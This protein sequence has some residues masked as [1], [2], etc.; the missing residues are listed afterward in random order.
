MKPIPVIC[1]L[2]AF[3]VALILA[4]VFMLTGCLSVTLNINIAGKQEPITSVDTPYKSAL[5]WIDAGGD[6]MAEGD[7]EISGAEVVVPLTPPP[8]DSPPFALDTRDGG[9]PVIHDIEAPE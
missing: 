7:A 9:L 1:G 8:M 2:F 4:M 5:P 3:D 6:V